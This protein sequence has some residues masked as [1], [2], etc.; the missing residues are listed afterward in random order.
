MKVVV[1]PVI[2]ILAFTSVMMS[3]VSKSTKDSFI[4]QTGED[5]I[6]KPESVK[7]SLQLCAYHYYRE[8]ESCLANCWIEKYIFKCLSYVQRDTVHTQ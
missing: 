3:P 1:F 4:S 7:S 6:D 2:V 5:C 8:I